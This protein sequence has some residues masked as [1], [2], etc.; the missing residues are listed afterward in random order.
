[1]RSET[2]KLVDKIYFLYYIKEIPLD[3]IS[4]NL[5][6]CKGYISNLLKIKLEPQYSKYTNKKLSE[7]DKYLMEKEFETTT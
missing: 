5:N 4:E 1:M 2:K 6:Y 3:E 7:F